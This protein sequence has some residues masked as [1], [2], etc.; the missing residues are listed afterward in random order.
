MLIVMGENFT[1]WSK[2]YV[3]NKEQKTQY[4]S[5]DRLLVENISIE[6]EDVIVVGQQ[7][8]DKEVLSSTHAYYILNEEKEKEAME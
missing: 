1:E 6:E 2:V 7:T 3:N 8:E 5:R 4:I